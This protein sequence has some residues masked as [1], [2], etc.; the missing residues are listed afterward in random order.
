MPFKSKKQRSFLYANKPEIA[1]K[2]SKKYGS[3]IAKKETK[4]KRK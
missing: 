1:K 4:K 2:W 3:K